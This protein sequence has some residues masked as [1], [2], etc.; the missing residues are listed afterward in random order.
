MIQI[1]DNVPIHGHVNSVKLDSI[2]LIQVNVREHV[3]MLIVQIV[4]VMLIL[5]PHVNGH[6]H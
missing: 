3:M 1:V 2:M 5:V 6:I 4:Q